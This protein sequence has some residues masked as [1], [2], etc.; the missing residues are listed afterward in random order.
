VVKTHKIFLFL[1]LTGVVF[2]E[3]MYPNM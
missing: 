2:V 1:V 3:N